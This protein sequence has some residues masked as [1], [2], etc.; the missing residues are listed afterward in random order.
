MVTLTTRQMLDV[1]LPSNFAL[2]NPEVLN[3]T[4]T[5]GGMNLMRGWQ[6]FTE[7]TTRA[8]AG[9]KPVGVDA[10]E[11]GRNM[12]SASTFDRLGCSA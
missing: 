10:F 9:K 5:Q 2:T 1:F 3:K 12:A 11:V 4:M 8:N 6:N 7:D